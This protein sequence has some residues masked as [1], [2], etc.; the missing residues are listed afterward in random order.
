MVDELHHVSHRRRLDIWP[1]G[2]NFFWLHGFMMWTAWYLFVIIQVGTNRYCKRCHKCSIYV[3]ACTGFLILAITCFFAYEAWRK[4]GGFKIINNSHSYVAFP[5][6]FGLFFITILGIY[7]RWAKTHWK[8]NTR[9]AITLTYVHKSFAYF[10]IIC[11]FSAVATGMHFYR[12]N[13]GR[14]PDF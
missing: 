13:P 5:C 8:W 6:V 11:G 2:Y 9:D 4:I 12:T 7:S 10:I 3:H 14:G 1:D